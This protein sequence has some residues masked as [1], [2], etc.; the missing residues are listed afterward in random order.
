M[1]LKSQLFLYIGPEV[2]IPAKLNN[3]FYD[4]LPSQLK[5]EMLTGTFGHSLKNL[6][7]SFYKS[8]C[9]QYIRN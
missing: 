6:K 4:I 3:P 5:R 8:M 1:N 2:V 7:E 9:I